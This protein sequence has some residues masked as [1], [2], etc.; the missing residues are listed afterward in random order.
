[1]ENDKPILNGTVDEAM[2]KMTNGNYTWMTM[3][4]GKH[5]GTPIDQLEPDYVRWCI[6]N[7]D[8]EGDLEQQLRQRFY[9]LGK[10]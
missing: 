7:M 4:F 1:M 10:N 2:K 6:N 5:K 3:P 8:L 9:D